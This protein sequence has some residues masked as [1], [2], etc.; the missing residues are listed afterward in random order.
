MLYIFLTAII[1]FIIYGKLFIFYKTKKLKNYLNENDIELTKVEQW[2]ILQSQVQPHEANYN[3][4]TPRYH[5]AYIFRDKLPQPFKNYAL[6][7]FDYEILYP[8]FNLTLEDEMA[9]NLEKIKNE[10]LT[11]NK[12]NSDDY[13]EKTVNGNYTQMV[14]ERGM[15]YSFETYNNLEEIALKRT[16]Y[17]SKLYKI[18]EY[19]RLENFYKLGKN[20]LHQFKGLSQHKDLRL[21]YKAFVLEEVFEKENKCIFLAFFKDIQTAENSIIFENKKHLESA[22]DPENRLFI[23]ERFFYELAKEE[24]IEL[25]CIRLSNFDS[26][27]F[28]YPLVYKCYNGVDCFVSS[29]PGYGEIGMGGPAFDC[30]YL[31]FIGNYINFVYVGNTSYITN[32]MVVKKE[33]DRLAFIQYKHEGVFIVF[34]DFNTLQWESFKF[35]TEKTK[36]IE[37]TFFDH[38]MEELKEIII[39][40]K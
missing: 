14:K 40:N 10:L 37:D 11:K 19:I 2:E 20:S 1:I 17:Q 5:K 26:E 16:Q 36:T 30:L 6:D 29:A 33:K 13:L 22:T 28:K 12:N 34:Y 8:C 7:F 23:E 27:D 35:L 32:N 31:P 4:I 39:Q 3:A 18:N 25:F 24:K 15:W 21:L 9:F 38:S